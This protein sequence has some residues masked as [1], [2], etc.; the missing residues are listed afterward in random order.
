MRRKQFG[1]IINIS[2]HAA[3]LGTTGRSAYAASNAGLEA[4]TRTMAVELAPDGITVNAVAPGAI[5]TERSR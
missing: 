1:R 3:H 5:E 4:L 2:S